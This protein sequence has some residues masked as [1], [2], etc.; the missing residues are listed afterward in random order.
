MPPRAYVRV[1]RRTSKHPTHHPGLV[2]RSVS[3]LPV[4]PLNHAHA[5]TTPSWSTQLHPTHNQ[6]IEQQVLCQPAA[7][8][9][10]P[11]ACMLSARRSCCQ[12]VPCHSHQYA[13]HARRPLPTSSDLWCSAGCLPVGELSW[14]WLALLSLKPG[15]AH[16][17]HAV[18]GAPCDG[19]EEPKRA[20]RTHPM[21]PST[22]LSA[23]RVPSCVSLGPRVSLCVAWDASHKGWQ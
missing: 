21:H 7:Q 22:L 19:G 16:Q 5:S 12:R 4:Y 14:H 15:G 3:A 2:D 10:C 11:A 20:A 17:C 1:Q 23:M 8:T 6:G 18:Y 9:L 13:S